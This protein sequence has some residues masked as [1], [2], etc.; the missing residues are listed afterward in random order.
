MRQKLTGKTYL[1]GLWTPEEYEVRVK[2]LEGD[3]P[4][5][6][7]PDM[8][9]EKNYS[10]FNNEINHKTQL[11]APFFEENLS[12]TILP[13][14]TTKPFHHHNCISLRKMYMTFQDPT[15]Y[16]IAIKAFGD[17]AYWEALKN[18]GWFAPQLSMWRNELELRLKAIGLK[19]VVKEAKLDNSKGQLQAA[20]YLAD[21]GWI[22]KSTKGRP[23]KLSIEEERRRILD[24]ERSF[25]EDLKRL[26]G[27][28]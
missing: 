13:M 10:Y 14:Y 24:E 7:Y 11:K 4:I 15:E 19:Q 9:I 6:N 25:A 2:A 3:D 18:A 22:D 16:W 28:I 20:K 5:N 8:D 17:F 26:K 21:K 23:S 12:K 1:D 27:E